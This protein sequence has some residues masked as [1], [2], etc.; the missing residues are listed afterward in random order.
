MKRNVIKNIFKWGS[1]FCF[2]IAAI[3]IL[4]ESGLDGTT[5][6]NQSNT[7]TDPI[8]DAMEESHDE[9]TIKELTDFNVNLEDENDNLCDKFFLE[10]MLIIGC[11]QTVSSHPYHEYS[12]SELQRMLKRNKSQWEA[13]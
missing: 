2:F 8:H 1:L 11:S 7:I 9:E 3:I 5:S 10:L 12:Q 13:Q 4:V 6:G